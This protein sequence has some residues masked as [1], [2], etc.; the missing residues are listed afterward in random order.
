MA[1]RYSVLPLLLAMF[2]ASCS[3]SPEPETLL[4]DLPSSFEELGYDS[5]IMEF[6][7]IPT[8]QNFADSRVQQAIEEEQRLIGEAATVCMAQ[9]GFDYLPDLPFEQPVIV[10]TEGESP[11]YFSEEW[12]KQYG[13]GVSTLRFSQ[14]Q[15]GSDLQGHD[16]GEIQELPPR[17]P[18]SDYLDSLSTAEQLAYMEALHGKSPEPPVGVSAEEIQEYFDSFEPTGCLGQAGESVYSLLSESE[19]RFYLVFEDALA[20]M[21]QAVEADVRLRGYLA[22]LA[23]CVSLK[24]FNYVNTDQVIADID[25][26]MVGIGANPSEE[27]KI[28]GDQATPT[29]GSPSLLPE[30]TEAD[31]FALG[32]IQRAEIELARAVVGCGGGPLNEQYVRDLVRVEY[33]TEFMLS[34]AL[35]LAEFEGGATN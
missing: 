31:R 7:G 2:A 34:N 13:F 20:D 11:A 29:A 33:E 17:D 18:N 26:Q 5:P 23:D 14:G 3:S 1:V 24:G 6:L 35:V 27:S 4:I 22:D 30:L 12:V 28:G 10:Y 15:V 25:A 9:E 32:E 16:R 19:Q 21:N 8:G